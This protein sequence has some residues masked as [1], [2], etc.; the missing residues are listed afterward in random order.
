MIRYT[1]SLEHT[2]SNS[3]DDLIWAVLT[4]TEPEEEVLY[5]NYFDLKKLNRLM[6]IPVQ[7]KIIELYKDRFGYKVEG[8][9]SQENINKMWDILE[10]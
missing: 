8:S 7:V 10:D 1:I 9:A 3:P 5:D 4:Q 6:S 2:N